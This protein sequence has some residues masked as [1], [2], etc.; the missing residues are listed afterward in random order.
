MSKTIWKFDLGTNS[1]SMHDIP[2]GA[3]YRHVG[4]DVKDRLCVWMEIDNEYTD[5][6]RHTFGI[7]NTGHPIPDDWLYCDSV[8][9]LGVELHV[10][11]F[12][13][14]EIVT[15]DSEPLVATA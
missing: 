13:E 12:A 4:L 5:M 7:F 15:A 8:I 14:L 3:N 2:A 9:W 6:E 10:H 11:R 1:L